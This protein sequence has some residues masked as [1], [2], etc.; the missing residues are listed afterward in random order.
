MMWWK[1]LKRFGKIEGNYSN[2]EYMDVKLSKEDKESLI[3]RYE[4]SFKINGFSPR[5]VLWT[6]EKQ[7]IRFDALI[8]EFNLENKSIL[9]LGCGF[10]DI[11]KILQKRY[12][13]YEYYG[14]DLVE[15]FI[16]T[17]KS[18]Y[19]NDSIMFECGDFL[20]R[21]FKRKYDYIIES[22]IFNI[23]LKEMNNY[24]FIETSIRK[25]FELCNE[26]LA[27]NFITERVNY[28][29]DDFYYINPERILE[30]AYKYS[31]K[32]ILKSD[33]LPFDYTVIIYKDD[34]YTESGIYN[35]DKC[36]RGN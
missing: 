26:A 34:S 13:K 10:G 17:A 6:E 23:K 28:K 1:L 20:N 31:K 4:G 18:I 27:F 35:T 21:E 24:N 16:C 33:Y 29:D 8:S 15:D 3:S 2:M 22:G 9:E 14:I 7:K 12:K 36:L 25:A 32:V 30:I 11:N 5:A 19:N